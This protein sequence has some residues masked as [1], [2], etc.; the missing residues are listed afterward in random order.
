[1]A[2]NKSGSRR[3]WRKRRPVLS[4][5]D[6]GLPGVVAKV[7]EGKSFGFIQPENGAARI[8]F[9]LHEVPRHRSKCVGEGRKVFFSVVE[10]K[11]GKPKAIVS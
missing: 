1:M 8:F 3:N 5:G 11:D 10:G 9:S 4:V 7:V 2:H 6:T